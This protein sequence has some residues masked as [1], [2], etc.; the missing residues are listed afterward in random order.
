MV[1]RKDL[2]L[3]VLGEKTREELPVRSRDL[4]YVSHDPLQPE[5]GGGGGRVA[6]WALLELTGLLLMHYTR[7]FFVQLVSQILLRHKLHE[8]LP[9]VTCPKINMSRNFFCCRNSCEK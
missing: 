1:N 7:Q 5:G 4:L 2:T 6:V 8:S 9:S 3:I